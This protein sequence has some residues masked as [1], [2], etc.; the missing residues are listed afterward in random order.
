MG[1]AKFVKSGGAIVTIALFIL[2][3]TLPST[4][5]I[6]ENKAIYVS[7]V[8]LVALMVGGALW[9]IGIR[10]AKS[11]TTKTSPLEDIKSNLITMNTIQREVAT[12]KGALPY[13]KKIAEQVG[14][15]FMALFGSDVLTFATS[16]IQTIL[17]NRNVD[18]LVDLYKK[19]GEIIDS[20][21]GG[22]KVDLENNE[23][24]K[25]ARMDLAQKRLKLRVSKRKNRII[26]SNIDR[27]STLIYGSNSY[28]V[29]RGIFRLAKGK[30]IVP[31]ELIVTMEGMEFAIEKT[32]NTMLNDLEN[33]WKVTV[34]ENELQILP[35]SKRN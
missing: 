9:F 33:E 27:T 1:K 13:S 16:L 25:T 19:F 8:A 29:L 11:E 35:I 10:L 14:D 22:L 30:K 24:Y 17:T 6:D 3:V 28:I 26:Q 18:P 23:S 34:N 12:K 15:D 20:N 2:G 4:P 5:W 32:L 7:I 21:T 31:T